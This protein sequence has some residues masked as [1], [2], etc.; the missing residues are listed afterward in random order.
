MRHAAAAFAVAAGLA[1]GLSPHEARAC[2]PLMPGPQVALPLRGQTAVPLNVQVRLFLRETAGSV[3]FD[4]AVLQRA[5]A[6]DGGG[7]LQTGLEPTGE[8]PAGVARASLIPA[9]PLSPETDYA[10]VGRY[11]PL[12]TFRTGTQED[13]VAPPAPAQVASQMTVYWK[14]PNSCDGSV[15]RYGVLELTPADVGEPVHFTVREGGETVAVDQPSTPGQPLRALVACDPGVGAG[16]PETWR[17]TPGPHTLELRAVDLAGNVSA[18]I[19]VSVNADCSLPVTYPD[20]PQPP[21]PAPV[22][23]VPG[24]ADGGVGD[25]AQDAAPEAGCR[26]TAAPSAVLA[27]ALLGLLP[28]RRGEG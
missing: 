17:L 10:V 18:P 14:E 25:V 23:P 7:G 8:V 4:E 28:R 16:L 15:G 22:T 20:P 27:L 13:H 19:T 26:Q 6:P 21:S 2:G 5:D 3:S 11:G 9:Q 12:T 24:N 1:A